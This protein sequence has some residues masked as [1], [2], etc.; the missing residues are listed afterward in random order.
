MNENDTRYVLK[1]QDLKKPFPKGKIHPNPMIEQ[2]AR[3]SA[4]CKKIFRPRILEELRVQALV[5]FKPCLEH[6]DGS[7]EVP[8]L[9]HIGYPHLILPLVRR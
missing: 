1:I 7:P 3:M 6:C 5:F 9:E 2:T 8:L 4:A